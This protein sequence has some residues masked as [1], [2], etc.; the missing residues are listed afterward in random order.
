VKRLLSESI[1]P[2]P[3]FVRE[4]FKHGKPV[5]T[6]MHAHNNLSEIF[7]YLWT[8]LTTRG[9]FIDLV[10][11]IVMFH[12]SVEGNGLSQPQKMLSKAD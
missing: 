12:Q 2:L 1:E 3:A 4:D 6:V 8:S 7:H 10:I 5:C 9:S 11:R